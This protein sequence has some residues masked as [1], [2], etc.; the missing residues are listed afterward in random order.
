[1]KDYKT[2]CVLIFIENIDKKMGSS[3]SH[4]VP[5]ENSE[6]YNTFFNE[7]FKIKV[8]LSICL[9]MF[10]LV[11]LNF[12]NGR[13]SFAKNKGYSEFIAICVLIAKLF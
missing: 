13:T 6:Q 10:T 7:K 5:G 2:V 9:L 11:D 12:N 3:S 4:P 8:C 1:M